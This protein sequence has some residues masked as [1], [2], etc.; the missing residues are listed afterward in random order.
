[1]EKETATHSSV[2]AWRIPWTEEPGGLQSTGL[3]ESDTTERL[4]HHHHNY[5][6]QTLG[7][8]N[9]PQE[10]YCVKIHFGEQMNHTW[11]IWFFFLI[12]CMFSCVQLF[13]TLWAVAVQAPL[14]MEFS[15][16]E[17]WNGLPF[18]LSGIF[19][20]Q[21]SNPRLLHWLVDSLLCEQPTGM[22]QDVLGNKSN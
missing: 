11:E 9:H 2:L 14:S 7:G 4:N 15:R 8:L 22:C 1:M 13:V 17:F 19:L 5:H 3:Q 18:P 20:I 6:C 16:Q 21:G 12:S 10:D